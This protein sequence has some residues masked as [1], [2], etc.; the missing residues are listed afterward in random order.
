MREIGLDEFMKQPG[1]TQAKAAALLGKTQGGICWMLNDIKQ[2]DREI[3][4]VF[5]DQ[6]QLID[7]YSKRKIPLPSPE[8]A[9]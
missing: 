5:N 4:L 3:R 6:D 9:A 1:M 7:C 2:G 8:Q